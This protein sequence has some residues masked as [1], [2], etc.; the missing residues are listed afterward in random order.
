MKAMRQH[1]QQNRHLRTTETG[2]STGSSPAFVFPRATHP[3]RTARPSGI[4]GRQKPS[5]SSPMDTRTEGGCTFSSATTP[6][7]QLKL[8]HAAVT[9]APRMTVNFGGASAENP[10]FLASQSPKIVLAASKPTGELLRNLRSTVGDKP[11]IGTTAT[12]K[13]NGVTDAEETYTKRSGA[14]KIPVWFFEFI[15]ILFLFQI[16]KVSVSSS[17]SSGNTNNSTPS[18][19]TGKAGGL[20]RK[21]FS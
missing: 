16:Q 14:T 1:R 13:Q 15:F 21:H 7:K 19:N 17:T 3:T 10:T 20:Y 18:T 5:S 2:T 11:L 9:T 4:G 8:S 12:T 6:I